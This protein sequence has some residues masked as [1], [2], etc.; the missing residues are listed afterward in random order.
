M[1]EVMHF[2]DNFGFGR[3]LCALDLAR[4]KSV[5]DE[6]QRNLLPA[7]SGANG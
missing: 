5:C 2:V 1:C 4:A 6:G 7:N 3:A